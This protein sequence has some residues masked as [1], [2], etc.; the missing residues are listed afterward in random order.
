MP[1]TM[2]KTPNAMLGRHLG[3]KEPTDEQRKKTL[4]LRN[5]LNLAA[6]PVPPTDD[7]ASK[8]QEALTK[9]MNNDAEGCCVITDL[10]KR[11]GIFNAYRP[12]GK[13]LVATDKEV[14]AFY[15]AVGG[16]GDN[17]LVMVEAWDFCIKHGMKIGGT[18]HFMEGYASVDVT[19]DALVDAATHWFGGLSLGVALTRQQ[20]MHAEDTDTWDIDGTN[21]VGGHAIPMTTRDSSRCKIATWARQP[22][23]TRRLLRSRGWCDEAYVLL[24]PEWFNSANI[25]VNGVNVDALRE[26]LKAI[27]NG[28]TPDIPTDPNP[29]PPPPGPPPGPPP[30]PGELTLEGYMEVFGQKLPLHLQGKFAGAMVPS[31]GG[32]WLVIARDVWAIVT[33]LGRR[34]WVALMTAVEQLLKDIGVTFSADDRHAFA[35]ALMASA[36]TLEMTRNG[37]E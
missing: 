4:P 6:R 23:I 29:P 17:G 7:Y 28:G 18:P 34:D 2:P 20:Y 26:A 10:A 3:R 32:N 5:F 24:G 35:A 31:L 12:G 27:K 36:D 11:F 30:V 22:H 9:M 13:I 37:K 16:P 21:V 8:A 33:A 15:H 14:S 19:D 1:P 25:D